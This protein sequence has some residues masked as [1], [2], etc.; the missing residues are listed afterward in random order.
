MATARTSADSADLRLAG[1]TYAIPF[2]RVWDASLDLVRGELHHW[3]ARW[4]DEELGVIQ[5]LSRGPLFRRVSDVVIRIRLDE[6]A[7]T[8]VDLRSTS[9]F[10]LI[11][12]FGGNNRLIDVFTNALDRKL[13]QPPPPPVLIAPESDGA[14][15]EATRPASHPA[16]DSAPAEADAPTPDETAAT[17]TV[18]PASPG[19]D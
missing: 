17:G 13:T 16:G 1:R 19:S 18:P 10:T 4:W 6:Q 11:G 12:D 14:D 2:A 15:L 3:Y 5:A 7:Q 8:R 9:R